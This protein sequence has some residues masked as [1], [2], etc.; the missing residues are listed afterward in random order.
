MNFI[1]FAK[2]LAASD[3]VKGALRDLAVS[4]KESKEAAAEEN[5]RSLRGPL[6]SATVQSAR[7]ELLQALLSRRIGK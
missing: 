1:S 7:S 4:V 5:S 6:G 2:N 3:A